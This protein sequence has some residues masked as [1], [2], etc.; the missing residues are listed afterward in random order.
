MVE[1]LQLSKR[2]FA[3]TYTTIIQPFEKG[4]NEGEIVCVAPVSRISEVIELTRSRCW[5]D[6]S[7]AEART[8]PHDRRQST[9]YGKET[10]T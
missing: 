3:G 1:V 6:A 8:R 10:L 7:V 9:M 4:E 2:F 5:H